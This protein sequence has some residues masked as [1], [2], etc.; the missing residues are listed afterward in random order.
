M[1]LVRALTVILPFLAG[2]GAGERTAVVVYAS[3]DRSIAEPVLDA[4]ERDTN[5]EVLAIYDTEANKTTGLVNRLVAE[6]DSP[7]ADVYWSGEVVQTLQLASRGVLA[8]IGRL[9]ED[10]ARDVRFRDGQGS[11]R[12]F[13]A[14]A[15]VLLAQPGAW[16][17]SAPPTV[18]D[19]SLPLWKGRVAIADPHFGTTRSHLA[20][21][22]AA[23]GAERFQAW[24]VGMRHNGVRI[25]PG[26]A[27]VRDAVV[28]GVVAVGLTDSDDAVQALRAGKPVSL[29]LARQSTD[30]GVMFIPNTVALIRGG[31]HM[32]SGKR[33]VEYL[34]SR[35][36]EAS[37]VS[38]NE[39]FYP[40]RADVGDAALQAWVRDGEPASYP[41]L[42]D[43]Q[44]AMLAMVDRE[45]FASVPAQ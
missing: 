37:L 33:L 27:Q 9:A 20:A 12:A 31:P 23:W 35:P 34:L 10:D 16:I 26:N 29:L 1:R 6:A 18:E 44:V 30:H 28:A 38:H 3:V 11:W 21:L 15:R 32:D 22:L 36:V 25:F 13:G 42:A 19:L 7:R 14:R 41:R 4:F 17:E 40:T 5:I 24:L 43:V 8:P 39:V 45:W 2:C